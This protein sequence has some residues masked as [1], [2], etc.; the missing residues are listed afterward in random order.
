MWF[1][2]LLSANP[3]ANS[4]NDK[5]FTV[6]ADQSLIFRRDFN[7]ASHTNSPSKFYVSLGQVMVFMENL[8]CKSEENL[9]AVKGDLFL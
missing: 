1:S 2:F 4:W 8:D 6:P 9:N 3:T 5:L 7:L